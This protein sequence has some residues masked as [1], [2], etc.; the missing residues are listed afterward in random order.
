MKKTSAFAALSFVLL[1]A[2]C[3]SGGSNTESTSGSGTGSGS[4]TEKVKVTITS[5]RAQQTE[6]DMY[7]VIQQ[8]LNK[9]YPDIELDFQAVKATE[10]N[11]AL[12]TA[13]QTNTAADIIHLRPYGGGR[14]VADAGYLEPIDGMKGLD[15]FTPDQLKAAQGTDGKQYGVPIMLSSTQ[16]LYNKEIFAQNSI[17]VPK[18]WDELI[19]D[20]EALKK[21][22]VTPL[23]FGSKEGW[24][25]SLMHGAIAPAFYGTDFPS[26]FL[27]GEKKL[28]SPEYLKSIEAFKSLTP[29]FPDNFEGLGMDDIRTMFA[30]GQTAMIIDGNFDIAAIQA[31]NPAIDIGVFPVPP[32]TA[33]GKPT[34]ST[35]VDGSFA[36]NKNAKNKDAAKKVLEFMT[37]K[38]YGT[39]I[40]NNA[41]VPSPIQGLSTDDALIKE[42]SDLS[43][44]S[45]TPYFAV[46]NLSQGDPTTKTTLENSLQ[47]MFL[48]KLTPEQVVAEEQKSADTWFK[49]SGS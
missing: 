6:T 16:F 26:Q 29:Y 27:K 44:S 32:A 43:V 38:E 1:A 39:I 33:G 41:K 30:T 3:S 42:I 8:E 14:K 17:Q 36:L 5:W 10:Y 21:K 34:V 18:T 46:T 48:G 15:Q 35:W 19:S 23:A 20:A 13:L 45:A 22:N 11:T 25:L 4:G 2:G 9:V 7:K 47:G 37:S 49:P 12:S 28:D 31:L 40:L 24:V